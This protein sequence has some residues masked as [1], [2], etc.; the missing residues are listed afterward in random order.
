MDTDN[1]DTA[2]PGEFASALPESSAGKSSAGKSSEGETSEGETSA[3]ESSVAKR[4]EAHT[5]T[6]A[7]VASVIAAISPVV[8]DEAEHFKA[9]PRNLQL[10]LG[11][12]VGFVVASVFEWWSGFARVTGVV[13][14]SATGSGNAYSDWR[15]WLAVFAA[16]VVFGASGVQISR[17]ELLS[18][19][20]TYIARKAA[21]IHSIGA[22]GCTLWL[23]AAFSATADLS[24]GLSLEFG[25]SF[26]LYAA[27][28]AAAC[29]CVGCVREYRGGVGDANA[30]DGDDS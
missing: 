8:K 14:Y 30:A 20:A 23:W 3:P 12:S 4:V 27:L 10:S 1:L 22:L 25:A 24:D 2:V 19:K 9:A 5:R 18:E 13:Q 6:E 16:L 15:G 11:G 28:A 29:A 21:L 7:A 17:R 26:G